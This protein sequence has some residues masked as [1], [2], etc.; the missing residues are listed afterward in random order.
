M[1]IYVMRHGETEWNSQRRVCGR[2]NIP[3]TEEG[4]RQAEEAAAGL[5]GRGIG[6]ILA[7]PLQRAQDTAA[8]VARR[9][10]GVQVETD[11]RLLEQCFGDYEGC[12]YDDA[13]FRRMR[14]NLAYRMPGG[15][16]SFYDMAARL[17]PLIDEVREKYPHT[18]VL[19]VAHGGVCRLLHS[20]FENLTN[21]EFSAISTGNCQWRQ[22]T[23]D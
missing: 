11:P 22:Y 21:E 23:V 19:L 18:N 3:L 4:R 17:Y 9:L 14:K 1:D 8:A 20:Y 16:E 10:E 6:V 2:S 5:V 15:G 12:D 13:E 7:S